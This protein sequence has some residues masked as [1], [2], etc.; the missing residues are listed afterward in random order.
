MNWK[1]ASVA[2]V[3]VFMFAC[4][5]NKASL[6]NNNGNTPN[7][8]NNANNA[9]NTTGSNNTTG[10]N[11]NTTSNN[12]NNTTGTNNTTGNNANNTTDIYDIDP[13]ADDRDYDGTIPARPSGEV[14][15]FVYDMAEA[16]C[17]KVVLCRGDYSVARQVLQAGIGTK[18]DCMQDFFN[19]NN[20]AS[21]A[22]SVAAGRSQFFV[23]DVAFCG[24]EIQNAGCDRIARAFVE[25][26][27]EFQACADVITGL[28]GPNDPCYSSADCGG[29]SYCQM[30]TGDSCDGSC[31]EFNEP[32]VYC[33]LEA[34]VLCAPT[35]YCDSVDQTCKP[36]T[37]AGAS[38]TSDIECIDGTFCRSGTCT[39]VKFN[40]QL[41]QPCNYFS[42][43][44]AMGLYCDAP[45]ASNGTCAE[46]RQVGE[47]CNTVSDCTYAGICD[48][49]NCLGKA[50][51][52]SCVFSSDCLSAACQN[53]SVCL[54]TT[55]AC[56]P[57]AAP[58]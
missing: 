43:I 6:I 57:P 1:R 48:G 28:Y 15:G 7:N 29:V 33:G 11:N 34:N 26:R 20:P 32:Q 53:D 2:A 24:L 31:V 21:Y 14:E 30:G 23:D 49:G 58:I 38:C 40:Y 50:D 52:G 22:E 19:R 4:G 47:S 51:E 36:Y 13:E 56:I 35:E 39:A 55:M 25:P 12:S 42:N 37:A 16:F 45:G 3:V 18:G 46:L 27:V 41:G 44:C 10:T 8:A 17:E 5:D 9:N 54:S